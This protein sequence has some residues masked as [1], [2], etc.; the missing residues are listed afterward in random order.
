MS[1]SNYL[2]RLATFL[3]KVG[4]LCKVLSQR[5]RRQTEYAERLLE[6][7]RVTDFCRVGIAHGTAMI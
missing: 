3:H 1:F 2:T 4:D 7:L 6:K 5:A